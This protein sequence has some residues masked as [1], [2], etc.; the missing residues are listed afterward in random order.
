MEKK[1][2]RNEEREF[3]IAMLKVQLKFESEISYLTTAMAFVISFLVA[4]SVLSFSIISFG[5]PLE[6][7]SYLQWNWHLMEF[8]Y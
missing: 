3:Q 2:D 4:I 8:F 6:V 5:I 7:E 1:E